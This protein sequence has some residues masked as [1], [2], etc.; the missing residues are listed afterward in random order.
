MDNKRRTSSS[1][2]ARVALIYIIF[3]IIWIIVSDRL[4]EIWFADPQSRATAQTIKGWFFVFTSGVLLYVLLRDAFNR[5]TDLLRHEQQIKDRYQTLVSQASVGIVLVTREGQVVESNDS[6]CRM[7]GVPREE[8]SGRMLWDFVD[9]NDREAFQAV[10]DGVLHGRLEFRELEIAHRDGSQ[11]PVEVSARLLSDGSMH[12]ILRDLTE[13]K[14]AEKAIR[15]QLNRLAALRKIDIAISSTVNL[16]ETL[17]ILIDQVLDQLNVDAAD[18]LLYNQETGRLTF[19]AGKGF[20]TDL[21]RSSSFAIDEGVVGRLITRQKPLMISDFDPGED[22]FLRIDLLTGEGFESYYGVPLVSKGELKGVLEVFNRQ[23]VQN[24]APWMKFLDTLAGQAAIAIDNAGLYESLKRKNEELARA[25]DATLEGWSR[26]LELRDQETDGHSRR[27]SDLVLRLARYLGIDG[28]ELVHIRRGTLLHD[29]GKMGVPDRI[30]LKDGPLTPEEWE[31]MRRHP[32]YAYQM[33]APIRYL[34][35]AIAIPYSH[36]ER[37][38]GSGY[39]RGLQ[40]QEIPLAARIFA[41][42]DVWDALL[43]N[44]PYRRAWPVEQV[45]KYLLEK[46]GKHFDP[47]IVDAFLAMMSG[48]RPGDC[49]H[50]NAG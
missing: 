6:A 38:D 43:S 10:M 45:K 34:R 4:V 14:Q 40:G 17:D 25:Y 23:H 3:S 13:R 37:W 47:Q 26:A 31:V 44:R 29:I 24:D 5:Y 30:L 36:H 16:D 7:L 27:V 41:V 33:L 12:I 20:R 46:A 19:A 39:P 11:V 9:E 2:A 42:V 35:P 49:S 18:V 22:S 28:E 50:E 8:L 48:G 32:E 21:I 1:T 15:M